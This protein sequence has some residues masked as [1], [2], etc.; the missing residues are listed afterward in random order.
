MFWN[1]FEVKAIQK[2]Q[3]LFFTKV[4]KKSVQPLEPNGWRAIFVIPTHTPVTLQMTF[5]DYE[6]IQWTVLVH[7]DSWIISEFWWNLKVCSIETHTYTYIS[8]CKTFTTIL[9]FLWYV[10]RFS[11]YEIG[12]I[13][14]RKNL[15]FV[16]LT[17]FVTTLNNHVNADI[18]K[19]TA[20]SSLIGFEEFYT[21]KKNE[22]EFLTC[23]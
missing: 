11:D 21:K 3:I 8:F 18:H 17:V 12:K 2:W 19:L 6:V 13:E 5:I 9:I 7:L 15:S 20:V 10:I 1:F 23:L 14:M 4:M 22:S 16:I